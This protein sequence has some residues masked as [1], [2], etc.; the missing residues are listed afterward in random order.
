VPK[1][2]QASERSPTAHESTEPDVRIMHALRRP[3]RALEVNSRRL[4]SET[5]VTSAQL[6]CMK[7]LLLKDVD[8]AT[9]IAR[10]VHLS[11]STVVGILDRLEDR[12]YIT[13]QRY[14]RDRRVVR[15]NLTKEGTA[16]VR[17]TPHPVR[18]LLEHQQN[19]LTQADASGIADALERLVGVLG[20]TDYE[21]DSPYADLSE[22]GEAGGD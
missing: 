14:G 9:E 22:D 6:S 4:A 13:R 3:V 12:N 11:P 16:L 17:R 15:V 1:K 7:M 2:K 10:R 19:G 21:V 5:G 20:A 8:T 18:N